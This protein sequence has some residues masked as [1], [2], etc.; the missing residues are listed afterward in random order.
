MKILK[1]AV[2]LA[3]L[4]TFTLAG[5]AQITAVGEDYTSTAVA[6]MPIYV[7]FTS[8]AVGELQAETPTVGTP[9]DFVWEKYD[10]IAQA[11]TPVA[12]QNGV[13]QSNVTLL[14]AG[15]YRATRDDGTNPADT[16]YAWIILDVL[17][18]DNVTFTNTC[19]YLQLDVH[20]TSEPAYAYYDLTRSPERLMYLSTLAKLEWESSPV[21]IYDGVDVEASWKRE[22]P[23]SGTIASTYIQSPAP[24][25][26]AK[27]TPTI[28]N[29]FGNTATFAATADIPALAPYPVMKV[30][31]LIEDSWNIASAPIKGS[32]LYKVR[33]D[34]SGSKNADT[35]TWIGMDNYNNV[36]TRDKVLWSRITTDKN[37]LVY[38]KYD[39]LGDELDGYVPGRYIDSLIVLNSVTG[40][41]LGT[42]LKSLTTS[43][44]EAAAFITVENSRFDPQSMPNVFTPNGDGFNDVFKFVKGAEPVS[45]KTMDL[46]IFDRSSKE[47]YRYDG[48]IDAW[49]GWN[50]KVN[51]TGR[52]CP[53]GV[54]YYSISGIGWDNEPYAGKEYRGFVHLFKE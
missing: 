45:M 29:S 15:G 21:D 11:Y 8:V 24:I 5:K 50:G 9:A 51:G 34:H 43:T 19:D 36:Q 40:C 13:L 16:L 26:E 46:R 38:P 33:F 3:A 30:E 32:A 49:E 41:R 37:E 10:E 12:T 54:Y 22:M 18:I 44:D 6:S 53:S 25:V 48:R 39:Y 4:S 47:I 2:L 17:T 20:H 14:G 1:Y 23:I 42:D 31:E 7:Y 28:K 27:Y 52:D 35:Y